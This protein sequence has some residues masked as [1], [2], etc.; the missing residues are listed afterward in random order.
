MGLRCGV[1]VPF[2]P[3]LSPQAPFPLTDEKTDS[4]PLRPREGERKGELRTDW[5]GGLGWKGGK[6]GGI[7]GKSGWVGSLIP[8]PWLSFP[9][10]GSPSTSLALSP[11][12][13]LS[14][15]PDSPSLSL[16][17]TLLPSTSPRLSSSLPLPGVVASRLS[18]AGT[19]AAPEAPP[20]G[21][22]ARE[23]QRKATPPTHRVSVSGLT[24]ARCLNSLKALPSDP[25][26]PLGK[27]KN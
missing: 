23:E 3:S 18:W 9:L 14:P 6:P 8:S 7:G 19:V 27:K 21:G 25:P 2:F 12:P 11:P 13:W 26:H 5:L 16:A 10:P 1:R 22:G 15:F 17:L 4:A 20:K 24:R